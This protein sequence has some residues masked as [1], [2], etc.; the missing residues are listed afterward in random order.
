VK[1]LVP[2]DAPLFFPQDLSNDGRAGGYIRRNSPD[3]PIDIPVV[4]GADGHHVQLELPFPY[5]QSVVLGFDADGTP[6]GTAHGI[7]YGFPGPG[8]FWAPTGFVALDD[9]GEGGTAI[10][11]NGGLIGGTTYELVDEMYIG[12]ATIWGQ[13]RTPIRLPNL[14]Q[15]H[16]TVW[17]INVHGAYVGV[18]VDL[19][20]GSLAGG[21]FV[22]QNGGATVLEYAGFPG[23]RGF[24]INDDGWIVGVWAGAAGGR[25]G[26][27]ARG[28]EIHDLGLFPGFGETWAG[29]INNAGTVVGAAANFGPDF[30]RALIWPNGS[31]VPLDLNQFILNLP[32][33]VTLIDAREINNAGQILGTGFSAATGYAYYVLTP[34]P[35]PSAAA[36]LGIGAISV[37]AGRRLRPRP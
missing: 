4:W 30:E 35:E 13:A 11:G 6:L 31:L 36:V 7:G 27:V 18:T 20:T 17:D 19:I 3:P 21:G 1:L 8:G 2:D 37:A 23:T 9:F 16:S 34:V 33:G 26:Y 24:E 5:R 10:A 32:P 29:A 14:G 12:R 25:R 22:G 15:L 28:D